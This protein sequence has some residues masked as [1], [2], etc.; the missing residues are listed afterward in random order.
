MNRIKRASK[1]KLKLRALID[2]GSG[3]GKTLAS[4]RL[5][6]PFGKTVVIDTEN[7][8]ASLYADHPLLKGFKYDILELEDYSPDDYIKAIEEC[9]DAGYDIIIIDSIA[10]E[11]IGKNGCLELASKLGGYPKGWQ[12]VSPMHEAFVQ[13]ILHSK[14]HIICTCRSKQAYSLDEATKKVTKQ[15]M[16][17]QQRDNFEYECTLTFSLNQAHMAESSKDRTSLFDGKSF[18]ITEDTGKQILSWLN[19][20]AEPT[21]VEEP[22]KSTFIE[23]INI[24]RKRIGDERFLS[25][26]TKLGKTEIELST[27]TDKTEQ[28]KVYTTLNNLK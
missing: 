22:K 16:E 7:N 8:S 21:P 9:E 20:G 24:I 6:I 18:Q 23:Q 14:S 4:L 25:E 28:I 10:H 26:L 1:E 3:S 11:W 17:P 12:K 15:G 13:K 2:G 27:M 5:A 19:S